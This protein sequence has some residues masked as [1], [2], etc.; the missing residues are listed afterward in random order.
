M[1]FFA[2]RMNVRSDNKMVFGFL[3]AEIECKLV[4]GGLVGLN[5]NERRC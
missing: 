3:P 5:V 2:D 1:C 4:I